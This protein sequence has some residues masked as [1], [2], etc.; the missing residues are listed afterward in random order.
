V[1]DFTSLTK[2]NL[3]GK[4]DLGTQSANLPNGIY[5]LKAETKTSLKMVKLI[6]Q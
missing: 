5:F 3:S 4:V 1:G 6:K 2:G